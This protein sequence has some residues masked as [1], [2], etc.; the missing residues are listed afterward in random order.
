MKE[1]RREVIKLADELNQKI[2]TSCQFYLAN[3]R[4]IK[5]YARCS[6][7][8]SNNNNENN[9]N[10][11]DESSEYSFKNDENYSQ[12]FDDSEINVDEVIDEGSDDDRE[13]SGRY[14]S[15]VNKANNNSMANT[16]S[17]RAKIVSSKKSTS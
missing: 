10:V 6:K 16:Y 14:A 13:Y 2:L 3:K 8:L 4:K 9:N 12:K 7:S 15:E 17:S 1:F 11:S 5:T